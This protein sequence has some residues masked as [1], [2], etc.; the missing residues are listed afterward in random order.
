MCLV[1]CVLIVALNKKQIQ[2]FILLISKFSAE[3]LVIDIFYWFD[4][5]TKRKA[6]LVEFC[7][8]CD[9]NYRKIIKHVNTRWL[10][11]KRDRQGASTISWPEE[12][13]SI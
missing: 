7:S 5:S 13:F 11:L 2:C 4:K 9:I 12:L 10:S 6:D 3:D 8:F 1:I